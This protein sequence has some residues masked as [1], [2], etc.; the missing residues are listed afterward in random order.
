M[1]RLMYHPLVRGSELGVRKF[2]VSWLW[3]KVSGT[4]I[5]FRVI[6]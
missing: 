3:V 5:G 6:N 2:K 1:L 4:L